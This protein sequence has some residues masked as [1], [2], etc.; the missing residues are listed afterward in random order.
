[1]KNEPIDHD[2]ITPPIQPI[3]IFKVMLPSPN[4]I[5][6]PITKVNIH[7]AKLIKHAYS[8]LFK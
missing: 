7:T 1:M 4:T 6:L 8:D 2:P 3:I 5:S